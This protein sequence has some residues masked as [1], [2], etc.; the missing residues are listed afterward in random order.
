MLPAFDQRNG[1][2]PWDEDL[3]DWMLGE[4]GDSLE[5][6]IAVVPDPVRSGSA[7]RYDVT[8]SACLLAMRSAGYLLDGFQLDD[9]RPTSG[10]KASP[11]RS[12][13]T[14]SDSSGGTLAAAARVADRPL[15]RAG[16]PAKDFANKQQRADAALAD[17]PVLSPRPLCGALTLICSG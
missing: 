16:S 15:A 7:Y 1:E 4:T 13:G 8:V 9:W 10:G 12:G 6:L 3:V 14:L 2:R 17:R 11:I 5:V